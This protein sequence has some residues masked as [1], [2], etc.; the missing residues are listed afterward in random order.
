MPIPLL[1]LSAQTP[2]QRATNLDQLLR[3]DARQ[4]FDLAQ[5]PLVRVKLIKLEPDLHTL[6]LTTHHIVCDGWSTNVLLGELAELYTAHSTGIP[7]KL[8]SAMAFREYAL[9]QASWRHTAE[10]SDTESWWAQKFAQ[11]ASPLELPTDRPRNSVKSFLGDTVRRTIDPAL[12]QRLKRFGA[13]QGCTLFATLLAGFKALLH[14]LSGQDDMIVGIPAAGQSLLDTEALVGHCVNF[15]PLRTSFAENPFVATLLTQVRGTLLDAYEHQ[16]YTYGS[17]IRRLGLRRD[18]SRL[19][20]VEVQFNLERVSSGDQLRFAGLNV[21][22]DACPKSFVNFDLFLNVVESEA[23]LV[24]DCDYNR[25]LFDSTTIERWLGHLQTLLEGMIADPRQEISALPL[26]SDTERQHLT[27]EWNNTRADYPCDKC[28]HDLIAEQAARTPRAVAAVC[29][30]RQLAY[31]DLDGAANRLAHFLQKRGVGTGNRVAIC[32]DRSLEMLIGVLGI[33]KSGAA[34]VPLDPDFPP[35]RLAAVL[36]D[37]RP[38]FL[39]TQESVASRLQQVASGVHQ[40][41]DPA[42]GGPAPVICLDSVWAEVSREEDR[43]TA[44]PATSADLAYVI[45]TSGSTG[46]PKGVEIP[47]RAV[48]NMLCS[49]GRRPGLTSRDTLLAV[50][51]LAFDIAVLELYL[52]LCVGGRVVIA[53][54]R[55]RR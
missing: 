22:V 32:L 46:K 37:A 42:S 1:D 49:M 21:E 12:Y 28:V 52:P 29:G 8:P 3:A 16:N 44:G 34:Y 13:Q 31:A 4:P 48:V 33:M 5:G 7:C 26:L 18:P 15:L 51:T 17:L 43:F 41:P 19:P 54:R 38:S 11:P 14:R 6:L 50:T 25:Q 35:E 45:Y 39:L 30:D 27:V 10:H 53:T 47:H 9:V 55:S 23:G 36:E 40:P 20:L 24:L 2:D